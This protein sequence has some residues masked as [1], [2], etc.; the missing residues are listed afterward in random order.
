MLRIPLG[1]VQGV[2]SDTTDIL[3]KLLDL[4]RSRGELSQGNGARRMS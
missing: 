4:G 2:A 3:I 1:G